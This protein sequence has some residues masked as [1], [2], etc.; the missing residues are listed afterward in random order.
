[1]NTVV[2]N[3]RDLC[4][5]CPVSPLATFLQNYSTVLQRDGGTVHRQSL[6]SCPSFTY[7]SR[8]CAVL[9]S[10]RV[11][12]CVHQHSQDSE[13]FQHHRGPFCCSFKPHPFPSNATTSLTPGNHYVSCT[14]NILSFP[15]QSYRD[16]II[17]F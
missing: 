4:T 10:A 8:V 1:M 12:L 15:P 3:N 14:L 2:R 5:F 11:G 6:L 16:R 17:H 13:Q 7:G 9:R